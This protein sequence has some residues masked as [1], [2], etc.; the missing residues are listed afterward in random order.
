MGFT[1]LYPLPPTKA[2]MDLSFSR[3]QERTAAEATPLLSLDLPMLLAACAASQSASPTVR[4]VESLGH[5]NAPEG[6]RIAVLTE[7]FAPRGG[8]AQ[9]LSVLGGAFN[10]LISEQLMVGK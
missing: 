7:V 3:M 8:A 1:G 10:I 2:F 9:D 5:E 4:A 6:D